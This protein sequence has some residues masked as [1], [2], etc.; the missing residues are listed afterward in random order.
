MTGNSELA[1]MLKH[2]IQCIEASCASQHHHVNFSALGKAATILLILDHCF[3]IQ[4]FYLDEDH[5]TGSDIKK[6]F[7]CT[8]ILFISALDILVAGVLLVF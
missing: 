5:D 2:C 8:N 7:D 6:Q 4:L 1:C 3:G